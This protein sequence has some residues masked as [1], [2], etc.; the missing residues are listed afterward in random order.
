[1]VIS[2][3][4][5]SAMRFSF[6]TGINGIH[7][8]ELVVLAAIVKLH[9]VQFLLCRCSNKQSQSLLGIC[10]K[11]ITGVDWCCAGQCV[12]IRRRCICVF[13]CVCYVGVFM[14]GVV[15][16]HMTRISVSFSEQ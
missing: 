7:C 5:F 13:M 11:G 15:L 6:N 14:F 4:K 16:S 3:D 9:A 10:D 1:M 2:S 8:K 12:T